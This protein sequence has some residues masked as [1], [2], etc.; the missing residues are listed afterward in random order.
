[1]SDIAPAAKPTWKWAFPDQI[2]KTNR[3]E[4]ETKEIPY[5]Y[6]RIEQEE[7]QRVVNEFIETGGPEEWKKHIGWVKVASEKEVFV[8]TDSLDNEYYV[9]RGKNELNRKTYP[10]NLARKEKVAI[11]NNKLRFAPTVVV[12]ADDGP[13]TVAKS[14]IG[15]KPTLS[16]IDYFEK[17]TGWVVNNPEENIIY[18]P[19][20]GL[21]VVD[22]GDVS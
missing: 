22:M 4:L 10:E 2:L 15:R 19:I 18:H 6:F 8:V 21:T 13:Y 14:V 7:G 12:E 17:V 9:K 3:D 11:A 1:M 20:A 5:E 16:E